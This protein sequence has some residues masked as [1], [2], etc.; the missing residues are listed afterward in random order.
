MMEIERER[1]QDAYCLASCCQYQCENQYTCEAYNEFL[2]LI[3]T[4]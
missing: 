1:V 3:K 4:I 2:K